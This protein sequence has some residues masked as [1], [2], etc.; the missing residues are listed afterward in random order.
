MR[1]EVL[2]YAYGMICVSMIIFN[3]IYS[4]I[5]NGR[6]PRLERKYKRIMKRIDLQLDGIRDG[7]RVEEKHLRYLERK[8]SHVSTLLA[9]DRVMTDLIRTESDAAVGGYL[10]QIQPVILHLA[11]VYRKR[12]SV[13]AAYFAYFLAKHKLKKRMQMDGLQQVM[14]EYMRMDSLYCRVNALDVLYTFGS[15]ENIV[16][17]ILLQDKKGAFLHEKILTE[18]LM[19]FEG[20]HDQLILLLWEQFEKFSLRTQL[21]VL[22]YIRFRTGN[23][24]KRMFEIMTDEKRNKELRFAAIRYMGRYVYAPAKEPLIAFVL[25]KDPLRWEYAAISATALGRYQGKEV[26]DALM[27]AM[28]SFNWY[29]RYNAAS[30]LQEQGLS[31][32]DLIDIVSGRDRYAREMLMYLMDSKRLERGREAAEG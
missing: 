27:E 23:D 6:E 29:V 9:F 20:D 31:Y 15:P 32:T 22:N 18:G 21:A 19:T 4:M 3:I 13:Q 7:E 24:K 28:H 8:L 16:E 30:S 2:L 12:E 26:T 5:V 17:A 10:R 14:V 11:L 25:D 1:T